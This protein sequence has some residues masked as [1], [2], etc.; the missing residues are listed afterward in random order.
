M[1][2]FLTTHDKRFCKIFQL[3]IV[4]QHEVHPD[5][6]TIVCQIVPEK[7]CEVN[8]PLQMSV[9]FLI[10]DCFFELFLGRGEKKKPKQT[11]V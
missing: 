3:L 1:G 8:C 9:K 5:K 4:I 6:A 2:T 7:L 10:R 11:T